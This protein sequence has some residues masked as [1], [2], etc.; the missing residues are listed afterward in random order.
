MQRGRAAASCSVALSLSS[1]V[2]MMGREQLWCHRVTGQLPGHYP[3]QA[4]APRTGRSLRGDLPR[5]NNTPPF[6]PLPSPPR[7]LCAH[8]PVCERAAQ[9]RLPPGPALFSASD[10]RCPL[11]A[12]RK[13]SGTGQGEDCKFLDSPAPGLCPR[14]PGLSEPR[15]CRAPNRTPSPAVQRLS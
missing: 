7:V 4:W 8:A 5:S 11:R 9:V 14:P 15:F 2:R 1:S 6:S 10:Q 13:R 12:H 3:A